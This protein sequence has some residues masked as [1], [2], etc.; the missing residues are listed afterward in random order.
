MV[1]DTQAA[2]VA[3]VGITRSNSSSGC[4]KLVVVVM[5]CSWP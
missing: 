1:F 4:S 3:L 2:V 5:K